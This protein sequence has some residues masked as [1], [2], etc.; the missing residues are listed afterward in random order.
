MV[1]KPIWEYMLAVWDLREIM[2]PGLL[3]MIPQ[4]QSSIPASQ[5]RYTQ[6]GHGELHIT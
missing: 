6:C 2:N 4:T 5:F 3:F 1:F